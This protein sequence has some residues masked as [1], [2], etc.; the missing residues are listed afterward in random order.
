VQLFDAGTGAAGALLPIHG[1]L[2]GMQDWSP[3]GRVVLVT[4][5]TGTGGDRRVQYQLVNTGTGQVVNPFPAQPDGAWWVDD[6]HLLAFGDVGLIC[7]TFPS[8][9]TD[10]CVRLPA[11]FDQ[12]SIT[13]G[14]A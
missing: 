4:G 3:D 13:V 14:R 9:Q 10:R 8:G 12:M 1:Y 11:D 2:H 5:T 6:G 7:V